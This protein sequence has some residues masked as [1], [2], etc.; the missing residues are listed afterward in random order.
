MSSEWRRAIVPTEPALCER[1]SARTALSACG[2]MNRQSRSMF[3]KYETNLKKCEH[4]DLVQS[5][6]QSIVS[7]A[8]VYRLSKPF[9]RPSS[10]PPQI[11][12]V[13]S[14][15]LDH[16]RNHFYRVRCFEESRKGGLEIFR[17]VGAA[18][19]DRNELESAQ[20]LVMRYFKRVKGIGEARGMIG[21]KR[22][23]DRQRTHQRLR[24]EQPASCF[25]PPLMSFPPRGD[26]PRERQRSTRPSD[27]R[28]SVSALELE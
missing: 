12:T 19:T 21:M 28:H 16:F 25:R 8:I 6:G 13:S 23:V 7:V 20:L 22:R 15:F 10:I 18:V 17:D 2:V 5:H 14:V 27:S 24:T 26:T 3:A 9:Q 11:T 4:R 1:G